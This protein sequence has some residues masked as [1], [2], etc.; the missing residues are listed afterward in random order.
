MGG[1]NISCEWLVS[2]LLF[3]QSY[4]VFLVGA[5]SALVGTGSRL[6]CRSASRR[7][8]SLSL[9]EGLGLCREVR[10]YETAGS[11]VGPIR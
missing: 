1:V 2:P 3:C 6:D 4:P 7:C 10:A 8:D 9:G 11:L 5:E